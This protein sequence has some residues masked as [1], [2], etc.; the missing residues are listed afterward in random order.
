MCRKT[1]TTKVETKFAAI[2]KR[3]IT[4]IFPHISAF[5]TTADAW[6]SRKRAYLAVTCHWLDNVTMERQSVCLGIRR[7]IGSMTYDVIAKALKSIHDEFK[8]SKK[9]VVT[10]TDSG[11]NF[12]K[13]FRMYS[14]ASSES[15][16]ADSEIVR[17][18]KLKH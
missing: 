13:A 16:A 5:C 6:K 17:H 18:L 9:I 10:I 3:L 7:M 2:K 8:I 14:P 15:S 4:E 1:L 11:L 12:L